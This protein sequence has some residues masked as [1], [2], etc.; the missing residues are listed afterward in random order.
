MNILVISSN[1]IGDS[2]LSTGII[3]DFIDRY[4][5]SKLTVIVGPSSKQVYVNFPNLNQLI[6]IK[7]QK[8]ELHW[9][10]IWKKCFFVK[11][12]II[13]DFRSSLIGYLLMRK[14][15]YIYKKYSNNVNQINQLTNFF[16]LNKIAYPIIF[17]TK[18]EEKIAKNKLLPD[19]KYI[20]IAPGGNWI[21]KIWSIENFNKLLRK[22]LNKNNY[23]Y[24]VLVGSNTEKEKFKKNII[25]KIDE[26]KIIDLMGKSI[27]QTH[28]YMKRCNLFVGNDSG[29]MHLSAASKIPTIGLFGPT[30]NKLYSPYGNNCYTVQTKETYEDFQT[31]KIEKYKSYMDSIKVEDVIEVIEKNHL[32]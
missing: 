9:L 8:Y 32:I 14:K 16:K 2:I 5:N 31:Y 6:T 3:K 30:N 1:L 10:E 15:S 22:L 18:E 19:I 25:N 26:K 7:K 11:W 4:P 21:P 27:T 28:A 29:L 24:V 20:V 23:L 12:D 13:I 17:N